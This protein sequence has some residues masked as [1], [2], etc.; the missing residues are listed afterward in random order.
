LSNIPRSHAVSA[1][2]ITIQGFVRGDLR[3]D[4]EV[5]YGTV[6][7]G[8]AEREPETWVGGEPPKRFR[9]S[10]WVFWGDS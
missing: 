9:Q 1:K 5:P 3:L 8:R 6:A 4:A 7:G 10:S 2:K